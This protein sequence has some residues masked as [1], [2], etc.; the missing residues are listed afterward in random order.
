MHLKHPVM[1]GFGIRDKETFS[2]ACRFARG[3]IIGTAFIRT[4]EQSGKM[5]ENIRGFIRSVLD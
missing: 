3:G 1:V 2:T 5:E 4:L